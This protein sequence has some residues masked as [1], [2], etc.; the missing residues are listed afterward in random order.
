[1]HMPTSASGS[2]A[3]TES[4]PEDFLLLWEQVSLSS[5][6]RRT[7]WLSFSSETALANRGPSTRLHMAAIW[8][9]P[10][11]FVLRNNLY[12]STTLRPTLLPGFC[13]SPCRRV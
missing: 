3:P 10:V 4:W 5:L 1:M 12:A 2:F 7:R 8:K 6:R 13:V 9:L 11:I